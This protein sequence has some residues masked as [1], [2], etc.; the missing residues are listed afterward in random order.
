MRKVLAGHARLS[1]R[2]WSY[3]SVNAEWVAGES[4]E[5]FLRI[6]LIS[7]VLAIVTVALRRGLRP[8]RRKKTR[9]PTRDSVNPGGASAMHS[10]AKRG[11]ARGPRCKVLT[12]SPRGELSTWYDHQGV[13]P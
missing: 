2:R 10:Y 4:V 9:K 13:T 1:F 12:G 7:E 5:Y 8:R 3:R 6:L 11:K